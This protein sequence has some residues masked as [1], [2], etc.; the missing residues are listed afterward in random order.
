MGG[1]ERVR[2]LVERDRE[3]G[4]ASTCTGSRTTCWAFTRHS[5]H[6]HTIHNISPESES[7]IRF[8]ENKT[9]KLMH[10]FAAHLV[11]VLNVSQLAGK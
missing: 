7:I 9:T 4:T 5:T 3:R 8:I 10:V 11:S 6:L 1:L 2:V